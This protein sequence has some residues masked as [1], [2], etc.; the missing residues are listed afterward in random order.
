MNERVEYTYAYVY[1]MHIINVWVSG[2]SPPPPLFCWCLLPFFAVESKQPAA[3]GKEREKDKALRAQCRQTGI[4]ESRA[5]QSTLLRTEHK[6][7]PPITA[8]QMHV[9]RLTQ[10][11]NKR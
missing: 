3:S 5:S 7:D 2:V 10:E 1:F 11:E 6:R 8:V 4:P 9:L